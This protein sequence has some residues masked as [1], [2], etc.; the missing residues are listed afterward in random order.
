[1]ENKEQLDPKA[2]TQNAGEESLANENAEK[3][4]SKTKKSRSEDSVQG[5]PEPSKNTEGNGEPEAS[6]PQTPKEQPVTEETEIIESVKSPA[7]NKSPV[8]EPAVEKPAEEPVAEKPVE[9]T[10]AE[11]TPV[12]EPVA[13]KPV[14]ET[15][16]EETPVEEPVAEKPV[17]ET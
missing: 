10:P 12:E 2:N 9:E 16:A 13:E 3:K 14:E 17:E 15:P 6:L 8:A 4:L 11:E 7:A 5:E 1:M